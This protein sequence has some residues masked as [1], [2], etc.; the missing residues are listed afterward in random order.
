MSCSL[1]ANYEKMKKKTLDLIALIVDNPESL[2]P[3]SGHRK[4]IEHT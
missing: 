4:E 3:H 2:L 1:I